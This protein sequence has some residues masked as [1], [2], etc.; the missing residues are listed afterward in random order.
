[1]ASL[2]WRRNPSCAPR[3]S[4]RVWEALLTYKNTPSATVGDRKL[5]H[6]HRFSSM[7]AHSGA[8]ACR[9]SSSSSAGGRAENLLTKINSAAAALQLVFLRPGLLYFPSSHSVRHID[10]LHNSCL[11]FRVIS[12][13]FPPLL[14]I[15][16]ICGKGHQL[17]VQIAFTYACQHFSERPPP[18]ACVIAYFADGRFPAI[19]SS[20][21]I[22]RNY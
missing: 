19:N 1:M 18:P 16:C 3:P 21:C 10:F 6:A 17:N 2:S 9:V 20:Y 11:A 13:F 15:F 14:H 7:L 8:Q 22:C 12:A 5:L 4:A